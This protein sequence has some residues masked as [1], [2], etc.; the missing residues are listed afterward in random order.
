FPWLIPKSGRVGKRTMS[1]G[2]HDLRVRAEPVPPRSSALMD[3]RFYGSETQRRLTP[4]TTRAP[5]ATQDTPATC[6]PRGRIFAK[7]FP[8][9]VH[10]PYD[11]AR[12]STD[13]RQPA[14]P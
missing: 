3:L 7:S 8:K 2:N 11:G 13:R 1:R 12:L 14:P 5:K 4:C 10:P 6:G 9:N